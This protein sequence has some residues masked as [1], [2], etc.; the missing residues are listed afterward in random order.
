[1]KITTFFKARIIIGDNVGMSG[2]SLTCRTTE[3]RIGDDTMIAPNVIIVD[4]DFHALSSPGARIHD[5]G[6]ENDRPVTIGKNVWIGMNSIV[7][8]GVTIGDKAIIGAGSVVTTDIPA[9]MIAA[10]NPARA[11]KPIQDAVS[12][13]VQ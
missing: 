2:T 12:G 5:M 6:Y 10:G 9:K 1:M 11:V 13:A 3:I 4:S 8:K 7:L